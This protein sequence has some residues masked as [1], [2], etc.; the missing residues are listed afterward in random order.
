[1]NTVFKFYLQIWT[2]WGISGAVCLALIIGQKR[3]TAKN[4]PKYWES[5]YQKENVSI[6]KIID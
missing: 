6:F 2:I 3:A 4:R 5:V 1:M